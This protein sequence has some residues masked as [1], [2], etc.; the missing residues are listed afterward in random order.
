MNWSQAFTLA[1]IGVAALTSVGCGDVELRS[2]YRDAAVTVDGNFDD[3]KGKLEFVEKA[4]MSVGV[5]NDDTDLYVILVI[6]DRETQRSI[7]MSGMFLWFDAAG[8]RDKQFGIHYP[9]GIQDPTSLMGPGKPSS[10]GDPEELRKKFAEESLGEAELIAANG[11]VRMTRSVSNLPGITL[12]TSNDRGAMVY[13]YRIPLAADVDS[14]Y[15]VG[16]GAGS[17]VG[18]GLMTPEIDTSAMRDQMREKMGPGGPGGRGAGG[19]R[20]GR[21][22]GMGGGRGGGIPSVP[23]PIDVWATLT[24]ATSESNDD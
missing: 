7:M 21:G 11:T 9:L 23:D 5:Q 14:P 4:N 8:A 3:W 20:G 16:T 10:G 24:L 12:A 22:G 17:V 18:V 19:G 2:Y 6:G 1:T 13:E 15:G